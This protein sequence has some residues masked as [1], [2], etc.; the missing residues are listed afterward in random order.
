MKPSIESLVRALQ[1]MHNRACGDASSVYMSIP[2]DHARD[3]DL[4]LADALIELK[5]YREREQKVE[6]EK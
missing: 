4:M 3:A 6:Q 2:A 5:G 1:K